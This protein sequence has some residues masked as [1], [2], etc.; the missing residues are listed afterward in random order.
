MSE[1]NV[2]IERVI[3]WLLLRQ[4]LKKILKHGVYVAGIAFFSTLAATQ[5]FSSAFWAS[6]IAGGTGG[7][8]AWKLLGNP[9][10]KIPLNK[11]GQSD[12]LLVY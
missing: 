10:I 1:L 5:D 9:E 8:A 12:T 3:M 6:F 4:T 11:K 2:M 7:L